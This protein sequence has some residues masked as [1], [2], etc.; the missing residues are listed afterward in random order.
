MMLPNEPMCAKS[1]STVEIG[2]VVRRSGPSKTRNAMIF[3]FASNCRKK[4]GPHYER[5]VFLLLLRC[6]TVRRTISIH[7]SHFACPHS[8][9]RT[10]HD[11]DSLVDYAPHRAR[12]RTRTRERDMRDSATIAAALYRHGRGLQC[13]DLGCKEKDGTVDA[14]YQRVGSCEREVALEH[15]SRTGTFALLGSTLRPRG[16]LS[17]LVPTLRVSWRPM[18]T[19]HRLWAC[20]SG[21]GVADSLRGR[22]VML[23]FQT[24]ISPSTC[25]GRARARERKSPKS[26]M[27]RCPT[28]SKSGSR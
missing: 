13:T 3:A 20:D 19:L 6:V 11:I 8:R 7:S 17:W 21:A 4:V 12:S 25:N 15:V 10:T 1:R 28:E 24:P 23:R 9:N 26:V 14:G 2:V 5:G 22:M 27:H 18:V 16:C